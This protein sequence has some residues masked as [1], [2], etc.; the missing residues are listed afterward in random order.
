VLPGDFILEVNGEETK[1]AEQIQR[2]VADLPPGKT[3]PIDVIRGGKKSTLSVFIEVR[4]DGAASEGC[5]RRFRGGR[6]RQDSG[7]VGG[8]ERPRSELQGIVRL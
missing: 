2:I 1:S 7:F 6:R 4:G 3:V 8:N 5:R